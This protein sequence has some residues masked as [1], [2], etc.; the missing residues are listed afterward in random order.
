MSVNY[1]STTC[2]PHTMSAD[3]SRRMT[4]TESATHSGSR[5]NEMYSSCFEGL[6]RIQADNEQ[7]MK[8]Q[9]RRIPLEMAPCPLALVLSTELPAAA[10]YRAFVLIER[11]P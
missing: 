2:K 6:A 7:N 4:L 11:I 3:K 9:R 1:K 8:T 10:S 5:L